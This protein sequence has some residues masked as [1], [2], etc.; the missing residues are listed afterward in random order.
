MSESSRLREEIIRLQSELEKR[1]KQL[2]QLQKHC[3]HDFQETS[4]TRTCIKCSLTES[5]YY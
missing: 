1:Q 4:L 3:A 2:S 5:L